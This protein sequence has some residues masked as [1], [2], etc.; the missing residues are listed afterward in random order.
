MGARS[1]GHASSP[2]P[3]SSTASARAARGDAA[4]PV[5][6][7]SGRRWR[8]ANRTSPSASIAGPA[9]R[10]HHHDRVPRDDADVAVHAVHRVQK[11][12]RRAGRGQRRGHLASDE[13]GLADPRH[14]R[15]P[16][17]RRDELRGAE[18]V[19][20]QPVGQRAHGHGLGAQHPPPLGQQGLDGARDHPPRSAQYSSTSSVH[21]PR[22]FSTRLGEF[23]HRP[24]PPFPSALPRGR[25]AHLGHA[26]RHGCGKTH[27]AQRGQVGQI[28]AQERDLAPRQPA[29]DQQPLH[30][31]DLVGRSVLPRVAY[32]ELGG[33]KPRGRRH[34]CPTRSRRG[35]PPAAASSPPGRPARRT[36]SARRVLP[37]RLRRRRSR[38]RS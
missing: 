31:R 26:V 38:R 17:R 19:V 8:S 1:S 25:A 34:P 14:G 33:A 36:A 24:P 2:T 32:V 20:S 11:H 13:P 4:S 22:A 28:V 27:P 37:L 16:A 3:Q 7:I 30:D 10:D 21:C 9:P 12:G 29:F 23:A 6:A 5:I 35:S 18:E 15:H